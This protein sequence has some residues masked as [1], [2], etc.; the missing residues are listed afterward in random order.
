MRQM[1]EEGVDHLPVVE[2][3]Q[4]IGVIARENLIDFISA[5]A[6]PEV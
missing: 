6:R 1:T 2:N 5:Q 4:F 3:G